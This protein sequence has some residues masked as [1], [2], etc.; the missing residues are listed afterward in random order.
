M[1]ANEEKRPQGQV[2]PADITVQ[3][4]GTLF[5][6]HANTQIG[7]EWIHEHVPSDATY[8]AGSLVVEARYAGDLADGMVDDGL[9]LE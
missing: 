9:V 1:T 3:G 6:F 5:L 8:W 4:E 7:R 2:T